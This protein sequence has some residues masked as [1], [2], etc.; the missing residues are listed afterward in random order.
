MIVLGNALYAQYENE[1]LIAKCVNDN[2][3]QEQSMCEAL[4]TKSLDPIFIADQ[5]GVIL[6]VNPAIVALSGYCQSELIG[7]LVLP[8]ALVQAIPDD[9]FS[10]M[11]S[12]SSAARAC[13]QLARKDGTW[14]TVEIIIAE[15]FRNGD[16]VF[17]GILRDRSQKHPVARIELPL[18]TVSQT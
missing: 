2:H 12:L 3:R 13:V 11:V 7:Q 5:L 4:F 6:E 10:C 17:V 14:G 15:A 1:K 8:H 18:E 16:T 9:S